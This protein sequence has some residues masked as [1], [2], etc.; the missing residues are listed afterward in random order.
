MTIITTATAMDTEMAM[1][2]ADVKT[3]ERDAAAV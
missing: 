3:A 2:T 1:V